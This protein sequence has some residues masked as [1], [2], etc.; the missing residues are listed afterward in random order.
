MDLQ[1]MHENSMD[2]RDG[3]IP[4]ALGEVTRGLVFR[5]H[6]WILSLALFGVALFQTACLYALVTRNPH[7]IYEPDSSLVVPVLVHEEVQD[8]E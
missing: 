4:A 5:K 6:G 1:K 7:V 8:G 3:R 2:V